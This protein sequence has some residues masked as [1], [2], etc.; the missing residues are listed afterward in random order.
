MKIVASVPRTA[1]IPAAISAGADAIEVRL[2]HTGPLSEEEADAAFRGLPV[3]LILTVRSVAEGGKFA[4]GPDEWWE[5]VRPCLPHA[6]CVDVEGPYRSHAPRLRKQG[7]KI[8]ASYHTPE[9]P[10]AASLE[11]ARR[12]LASYGDIPKIVVGPRSLD[13]VVSL[14]SFTLHAEKP[15]VTGVMGS[16]FSFARLVLPLFGSCLLFC[17]AGIPVAAGQFHVSK[18]R[19]IM[20]LLR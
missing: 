4:G 14:L 1:L 5:M 8:I 19:E 15:I 6:T 12:D 9:M 20:D 16:R 7:K 2:D 3:P 17:H 13:D 10:S 11:T 18:A